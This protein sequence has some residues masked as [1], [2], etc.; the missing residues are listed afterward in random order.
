VFG[1]SALTQLVPHLNLGDIA[2]ADW[3]SAARVKHDVLNVFNLFYQS[4]ST[5]DILFIAMLDEVRS[6]VLI[7]VLNGFKKRFERDVVIHQCLLI[8]DD[9][10]LLYVTAKAEHIRDA[11][12]GAQ[13]QFDYPVLN[14]A[15]FLSALTMTDDLVEIDLA[16]SG[17]YRSHSRLEPRRDAVLCKREPLED[18]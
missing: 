4:Q 3:G 12:H 8:D 17:G 18:L 14:S 5:N 9:V 10:I 2:D 16:G 15:Q 7:V 1:D 6:G 11:G 13:L